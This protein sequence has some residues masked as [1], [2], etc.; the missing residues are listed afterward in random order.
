MVYSGFG[1][2][3]TLSCGLPET[4]RRNGGSKLRRS[5]FLAIANVIIH[6]AVEI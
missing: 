3:P 4:R 2:G 5:S 6:A 1:Q